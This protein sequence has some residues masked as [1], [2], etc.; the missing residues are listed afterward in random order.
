[1]TDTTTHAVERGARH[2]RRS[3]IPASSGVR[4]RLERLHGL[5]A[6]ATFSQVCCP[7]RERGKT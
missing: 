7:P 6:A 1:M 5:Q 2:G 3:D 4:S